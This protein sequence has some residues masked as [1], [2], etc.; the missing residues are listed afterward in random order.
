MSAEGSASLPAVVE[1]KPVVRPPPHGRLDPR[2]EGGDVFLR[3]PRHRETR[4]EGRLVPP[5]PPPASTGGR[6]RGGRSPP[7]HLRSPGPSGR[8]GRRRGRRRRARAS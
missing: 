1:P 4:G 3:S 5:G 8:G 6:G 7:L 2:S